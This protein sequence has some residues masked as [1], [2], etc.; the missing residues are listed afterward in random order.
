V[1]LLAEKTREVGEVAYRYAMEGRVA[2]LAMLLLV[3]ENK[4]SATVS[5]VIEGVRTKRSI[6]N[7]VVDEVLSVGDASARDGNERR[8]ALLCEIQL[9][10]QFGASSWRDLNIDRRTLPPLLR[11][12]KVLMIMLFNNFMPHIFSNSATHDSIT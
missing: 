11:A 8:K 9:L 12:A 1:R 3:A 4:I 5:V 6:Y 7:F 10:N 2:A